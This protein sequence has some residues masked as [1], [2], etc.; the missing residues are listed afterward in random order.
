MRQ[1][2]TPYPLDGTELRWGETPLVL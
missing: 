2:E 1:Q